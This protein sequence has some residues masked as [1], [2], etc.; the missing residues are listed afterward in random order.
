M[1]P[2]FL[3]AKKSGQ[4]S[5]EK[6]GEVGCRIQHSSNLVRV[7]V[8]SVILLVAGIFY[9]LYYGRIGYMPQDS[10][11]VF[12]GGWRILSGQIP[13]LDFTAPNAIVPILLQAI[14]FSLFGVNWFAYCL[15]AAIFNGLFCIIV[16]L[17]LRMFG[18]M[19]AISFFYAL[20]SGVVFYTPFGIP[21]QDQHAFFFTFI[22]IFLACFVTRT[23]NH[24]V[25]NTILFFMPTL[26]AISFFSKQIPTIFGI[27][28][29][30]CIL[31]VLERNRLLEVVRILSLGTTLTLLVLWII[32]I[33][34][35]I[36]FNLA[37]IYLFR[38]PAEL[39]YSRLSQAFTTKFLATLKHMLL[40]WRLFFPFALVTL[41]VLGALIFFHPRF[42]IFKKGQDTRTIDEAP[43]LSYFPL[44]LSLSLI[45]LSVMFLSLTNNQAEN[46]AAF[47]FISLGL[48][49]IFLI[50]SLGRKGLFLVGILLCAGSLLCA[51]NFHKHVNMTRMVHD[52][53]YEKKLAKDF[54]NNMPGG[55]SFLV[56]AAP[57]CYKG[58]PEDFKNTIDFFNSNAGNFF[59]LGDSS[60]LYALTGRPSVNPALWF[61]P[62]QTMPFPTSSW[63]PDFQD[64]LLKSMA[65]NHTRYVVLES[66]KQKGGKSFTWSNVSLS[67]F[68]KLNELVQKTGSVRAVFGVFTIIELANMDKQ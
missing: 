2:S 42:E 16:F 15:H 44:L 11:A 52:L 20:I 32:F 38:L 19:L 35:G 13:F 30:L 17:F 1:M 58:T 6:T 46:G 4:W 23:Q 26:T 10:A 51:W 24:S 50:K 47:I 27:I 63:L 53:V 5:Q 62:G 37:N 39:G 49:H 64:L 7:I 14:S 22:L 21:F 36:D 41:F 56:W 29:A 34:F 8:L 65:K 31:L 59:L 60:I 45:V 68:P 3:A 55:L 33:V 9:C 18:G 40:H 57:E 48:L 67:Y 54:R 66:T 61:D 43:R 12:D 28:L 25:K